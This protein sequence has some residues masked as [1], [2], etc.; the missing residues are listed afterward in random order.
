MGMNFAL[1]V[2]KSRKP[3]RGCGCQNCTAT[4]GHEPNVLLLHHTRY[5]PAFAG[6]K[7]DLIWKVTA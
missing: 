5:D 7:E 2:T 1:R 3:Y 6:L 4:S